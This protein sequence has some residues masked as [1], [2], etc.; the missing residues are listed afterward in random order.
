[1]SQE[2]AQQPLELVD[3]PAP[4]EITESTV[5]FDIAGAATL[6]LYRLAGEGNTV[7]AGA[8]ADQVD[9][10]RDAARHLIAA[11]MAQRQVADLR[12]QILEEERRRHAWEKLTMYGGM[13]LVIIGAATL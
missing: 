5:T 11:G 8:N 3:W 10:L 7:I 9:D 2:P 13:L 1:M 12:L 6:E 4:I